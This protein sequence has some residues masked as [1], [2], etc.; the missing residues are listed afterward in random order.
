MPSPNLAKIVSAV[1]A[2]LTCVICPI[3][4]HVP[5]GSDNDGPSYHVDVVV[6]GTSAE[7]EADSEVIVPADAGVIQE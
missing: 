6:N 5:A 4:N 3:T 7:S 1:V 2:D